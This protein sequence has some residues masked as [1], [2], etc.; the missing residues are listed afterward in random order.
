M[1]HIMVLK[2]R[3]LHAIKT[4]I[5]IWIVTLRCKQLCHCFSKNAMGYWFVM[6]DLFMELASEFHFPSNIGTS[7]IIYICMLP[8]LNVCTITFILLAVC[9]TL[10]SANISSNTT[11]LAI[12][13]FGQIT[14]G[15][16]D[17]C[18]H[19]YSNTS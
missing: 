15:E 17:L 4:C 16:V 2:G 13:T 7:Q 1:F 5:S 10:V 18:F 19:I 6:C 9:L 8:I 12:V 14:T 11:F 3:F